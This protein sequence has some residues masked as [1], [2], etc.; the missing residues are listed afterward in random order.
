MKIVQRHSW[1]E[2]I[3]FF[4]LVF[5]A[6]G[7]ASASN[8]LMLPSGYL[9]ARGSQI[10][11][12]RGHPIRIASVGGF[13]T[14]IVGGRLDYPG[15]FSGV[16]GNMAAVRNVGFN[17]IRVDF[18]D[19][20]VS[21]PVLMA[22]FD[23]LV[24]ACKTH[25][26]KVIFD[27]H[28]NEATAADWGNAAQQTNGLWYDVGPGTDGTDGAG[29]KGTV[30]RET[31]LNDWVTM[32]RHWA[33]NTT[34]IGFDLDNEP[35]IG[36]GTPDNGENW[37]GGGPGDIAA[38]YRTVG[39]AIQA[40]DPGALIICEGLM[41]VTDKSSNIWWTMDLTHA[42]TK[43]VVLKRPHKVVYSV[44]EYPNMRNGG[45]GPTYV[46]RMN[47]DW[48]WL[49]KGNIA[50][51]WIGEMGAAMSTDSDRN[52]GDTILSYMDGTAVDGPRYTKGQQPISGDWWRWGCYPER[53]DGC[54]N[55]D[56][57][58]RP[59][60][61][62]YIAKMLYPPQKTAPSASS[63]TADPGTGSWS[64]FSV[65]GMTINL[66]LPKN[67][68]S[69]HKYPLVLYLHQLDMGNWPEGLMKETN[70]WFNTAQ[71]R[72]DYPAIV[73]YPELNQKADSS[74]KTINFGGVSPDN[75]PGE[76]NAIAAVQQ[77]MKQY[78]VNP[79]R[80]YVTGNS[81]GGI[82]TWD[83]LIK[84]NAISGTAGKIFAAGMP[85]AGATYDHGYPTPDSSVVS[86]L[87]NV[88]IWAIHGADDTQVPL[89]WDKAMAA[90]LSDA[91]TFHFTLDPK[92]SHDVWDTYYAL[93]T[94]KT[95][96]DWLFAQKAPDPPSAIGSV[97]ASDALMLPSG[98][99]S[100]RGSQ[101]VDSRG[102][103][104]RIACVGGFGTDIVGGRL[105]YSG[106]YSG[107][108]ANIAAV[109]KMGFNCL[110]VDFTDKS[111]GDPVLMGQ[112]DQLVA[113]C[114]KYGLKVI[115]D[116]H[117]DEATPAS[118]SNA[119]QQSNGLWYDVGPGTDGTD[120]AGD[121]GTVSNAQFQQDWVTMAKHWAGNSTVIGFDIRNEPCAHTSTPALWGGGGPTDIHAMYQTVGNMVLAVNPNALIICESV[122]NYQKDAYEGDLSIVKTLP[123]LI[124]KPSKLVY[125]VHEYPKEVGG[126]KGP[127]SGPGYVDRMNTMWGWLISQNV[128]PVWIGEMGSSMNT[129]GDLAWGAT[130]LDYMNGLAPGGI[131]VSKHQQPISGDWW[132]W[133][134][135]PGNVPDGCLDQ[136]GNLRPEQAPYIKQMLFHAK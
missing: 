72:K 83:I 119:A 80:V 12:S 53:G 32:A 39:N 64:Q 52:W 91:S 66:L 15:P 55:D 6:A 59:V 22:Q 46:A 129:P 81:M 76:V 17:C 47:E 124:R 61:S 87:K 2:I 23:Q 128:A 33:G 131:K 99:L 60:L 14:D 95:Y 16:D 24:S 1:F 132:A 133:G 56:G 113:A 106:P 102:H 28:N 103:P 21:D 41:D 73:I 11:D 118:W 7:S 26:L 123:I 82:G 3:L 93:P 100:A 38:M 74:G 89:V 58:V 51:V 96:W 105:E 13:G 121:K 44:H 97:N 114:K 45:G 108:D 67:Y 94:G 8:A 19:K 86:A 37:G 54:L 88:P 115:F 31:F 117:N 107:L 48:G 101:I 9:S 36:Y 34:V 25:G 130:L 127:E 77:V 65:N 125:S 92:L 43:P 49:I 50:P 10:V 62:A 120:G 63:L 135:Q 110:R 70:P 98:Y 104:V 68:S 30:S 71:W 122:I 27:H 42:A 112:F 85:L 69:S 20:S 109:R 35:H 5:A 78:S 134:Y 79:S 75:Q 111:V 126:Y 40:I 84:Y 4:A 57:K 90:S 29:D 136:T 18:N 116:N